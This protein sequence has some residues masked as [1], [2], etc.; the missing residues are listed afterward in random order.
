MTNILAFQEPKTI[1]NYK[2]PVS[3]ENQVISILT[4]NLMNKEIIIRM[5][6]KT[7]KKFFNSKSEK[8]P[9]TLKKTFYVK[10]MFDN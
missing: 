9:Q 3:S 8:E 10:T 5:Y 4:T 2:N 6:L 1:L 7:L